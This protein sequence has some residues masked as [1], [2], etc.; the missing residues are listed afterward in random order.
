M[1]SITIIVSILSSSSS[2]SSPSSSSSSLLGAAVGLPPRLNEALAHRSVS[3][4]LAIPS[5]KATGASPELT[6]AA[7]LLTGLYGASGQWLLD[8]SKVRDE[9]HTGVTVGTAAHAVGTA[10][11]LTSNPPAAA[12]ASV[13]MVVAGIFHAI[14]CSVPGVPALMKRLA[15][16]SAI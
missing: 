9:V 3:S 5:A 12:I 2:S 4:A 6:V 15:R 13:G 10:S 16:G 1:Y 14:V 7:V 11:L 8:L